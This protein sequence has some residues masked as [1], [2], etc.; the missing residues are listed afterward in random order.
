MT[1]SNSEVLFN[2]Q[3]IN[4]SSGR[5]IGVASLNRSAQL[6][7]LNLNM[8]QL[9]LTQMRQWQSDPN[10]IAVVLQGEG[11]KGFCAGGDVASVVKPILSGKSQAF[12][13]GDQFFTVEYELDYLLHTFGKPLVTWA[14]GVTMGGGVGLSVAGS[15]RFVTQNLKM[16]MPEI[17]IGLFPDVGG[18]WFLNRTPGYSGLLMAMTGHVINEGDAIFA[19]LADYYMP[20]AQRSDFIAALSQIQ[21]GNQVHDHMNQMTFACRQWCAPFLG[22][23][24]PS[25]L[26]EQFHAIREAFN[27]AKVHGVRKGLEVLA[28][29]DSRFASAAKNLNAGSATAAAVV[30]EYMRRTKHL[31]LR[32]V[33]NLDLTLAKQFSR[34]LDFPEG[35]RALLIDKDKT[36][37]WQP[38]SPDDVSAELI[39]GH[40]ENVS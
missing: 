36:P 21:W 33:L 4:D 5:V 31:S 25:L 8:C 15:H 18:G 6:N 30:F 29:S 28:A 2:E 7:A 39:G 3:R 23:L 20:H 9:L 32:E 37:I 1:E 16:A 22:Q 19:G 11:D 10:V 27:R 40:F 38:A 13:Y 34:R 35:V 17:H 24:A 26:A 12:E 14:H